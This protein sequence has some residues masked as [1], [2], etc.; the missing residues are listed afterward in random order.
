MLLRAHGFQISLP[1]PEI[2]EA[3]GGILVTLFKDKFTEEHLQKLGL[4]ERQI[5]AV[6]YVKEK[7][8]I[9]NKEYISLFN[10]SIITATKDPN[11]LVGTDQIELAQSAFSKE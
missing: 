7:G 1:E 5:K 11:G 8:R 9:A 10:V 2:K 3:N 4:N 6:I